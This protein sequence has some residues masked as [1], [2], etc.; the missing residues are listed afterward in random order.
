MAKNP[1]DGSES[2]ENSPV[3]IFITF[4]GPEGSGKTTQI[5][6]LTAYL[7]TAGY[8]V[9][10]TREPGGT[11]IGDQIRA[12]LHDLDNTAMV[13]EAEVLLYA[14]SRAQHVGQ[15][16]RPALA[17]G[18][19]VIS[20]RYA[21]S[22]LAYQGYGRGL[23]LDA[24]QQI[25]AFATGGLTPN[26]TLYLDCPVEEGLQRKQ[27]ARSLGKGEWN[28]LDQEA[29]AFHR[30]VHQ[31][32]L[33]LIAAEPDRWCVLNAHRPIEELQ[34]EIQQAVETKLKQSV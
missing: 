9:L 19:I 7:E 5:K 6:L 31:G 22:T 29:V 28:R 26:L 21:D 16:I 11:A 13:D 25:T 14:A 1:G 34:Q 12:V 30:R 18:K 4:E 33:A 2:I 27:R 8:D 10:S 32:Y 20:D 24:L 15:L 17:Q 23:D 3:G